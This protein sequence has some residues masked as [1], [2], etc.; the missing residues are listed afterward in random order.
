MGG[1][2]ALVYVVY[3]DRA[4]AQAAAR[5]M[6]EQ[7]LAACANVLGDCRSVYR[8]DGAVAEADECPV[9]FK[10]RP[11][12]CAALTT[13]IGQAHGYDLPA[14]LCWTAATT[15]A[16]AAWIEAGSG[17]DADTSGG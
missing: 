8:W 15:P 5:T 11:A 7:R 1:E 12:G 10:T 4:A 16:Y 14:I 17:A 13:A 3:A 9:L 2:I 6:V